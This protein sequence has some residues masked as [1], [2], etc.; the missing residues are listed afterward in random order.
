MVQLLIDLTDKSSTN[1][2]I[3]TSG[4]VEPDPIVLTV[5]EFPELLERAAAK[6][7]SKQAFAKALGITPSRFSRLLQGQFSLEVVNCLRLAKI[8]GERPSTV[9]RAAGKN[10]VADLIEELYGAEG[11]P[12]T[13]AQRELIEVWE[14]IPAEMQPHFAVLLRHARDVA[15]ADAPLGRNTA[16]PAARR[17]RLAGHGK[18]KA[19]VRR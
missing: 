11:N 18:R 14:G 16:P 19:T 2:T 4:K 6:F 13:P 17:R 5:S 7:P 10:D 1:C 12:L 15:D 8:A 3:S 9:L